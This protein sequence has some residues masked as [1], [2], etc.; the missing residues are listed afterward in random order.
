M[1][2]VNNAYID[3]EGLKKIHTFVFCLN[4]FPKDILS[5]Y[6]RLPYT[7]RGVLPRSDVSRPVETVDR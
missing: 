3:T 1:L 4:L 6:L 7:F 2:I 5:V